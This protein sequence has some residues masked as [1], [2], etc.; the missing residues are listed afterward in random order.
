M[1][2]LPSILCAGIAVEAAAIRGG[3]HISRPAEDRYTLPSLS[4]DVSARA[5]ALRVKREGW[6]Y[7]PS[8]A[9]NTSFY[10]IGA[11]ADVATKADTNALFTFQD[12]H[13][14]NVGIDKQNAL[15][16]VNATGGIKSLDE[17]HKLYDHE[18]VITVPEGPYIGMLSNYTS[19]LLFSMERLSTAPASVARV[20][21]SDALLFAVDNAAS[22]TG[23]SLKQLQAQGRL[24]VIDYLDQK[25]LSRS[26]DIKFG[27]ACQAYFYI[28]PESGD[29]LPLA[30]KPNVEGSDLVYTPEDEENDWTL[31]KL[32][33]NLNDLWFTQ[34]FHLAA[35]HE[36]AE[37]VYLA[38]IRTLSEEH[39]L[40][41]FLHR[42]MKQAWAMRHS[43][44]QRLINVGGPVDQLFPWAGSS[45]GVYTDAL[46]Q[47]GLA[48]K[49]R[50]NYLEANLKSRGLLDGAFGPELKSFPYL[51]DA[52][53]VTDAVRTFMKSFV[54]SYYLTSDDVT[55]D[56]ELQAWIKEAGPAEIQDF[57]TAVTDVDGI[58]D[59]MTHMCYLV[60]VQ[61]G[62][63]NSNSP[64]ASTASL[65][66][67]PL[68]FYAPLPTEKGVT[69]VMQYMPPLAAAVGQISLLAAFNRPQFLDTNQTLSHLFDDSEILARMN[70]ETNK[71]AA[72]FRMQMDA[73]SKVVRSR[74][75]DADGLSQG[76]PFIWN[77]LDPNR[78]P[79]WVTI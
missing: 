74:K 12:K 68:A 79:Y 1:I 4:V 71:A 59:I 28:H 77:A 33:F 35:G 21:A 15:E 26:S 54:S 41:P 25:D 53:L 38:A 63:L 46:Y 40:M 20:G 42:L 48:S 61:H 56:M 67:H 65:P 69:D 57:P 64:V 14:A 29:F 66:L 6:Q 70:P 55:A 10:P 9:G 13:T 36:T 8:I 73:F 52:T 78:A 2:V 18:W 44:E 19:D 62:V 16:A 76:M 51:E 34:W 47:S 22:I 30:I 24:F 11:L 75:F 37:I 7:G 50:A 58:V 72:A 43:A 45:A 31:A 23:L 17:Y 39:P 27:A 32:M 3:S 60:A 5:E 49:F